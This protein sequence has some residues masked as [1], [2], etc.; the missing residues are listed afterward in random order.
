M[1]YTDEN[2]GTPQR[3]DVMKQVVNFEGL[4]I[5]GNITPTDIDGFFE[6]HGET[7]VFFEVKLEGAQLP[8]GQSLALTRL[9]DYLQQAGRDAVLF[10]C[11]HRV[12][13][14]SQQIMAQ[15]LTVTKVYYKGRVIPWDGRTLR[16][17]VEDF[18]RHS[19]RGREL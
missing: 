6:I 5:S 14:T 8:K 3:L 9:V 10:V 18:V 17:S 2:R 19:Q 1:I 7:F 4:R 12:R 13:D 11:T 16:Q 15:D